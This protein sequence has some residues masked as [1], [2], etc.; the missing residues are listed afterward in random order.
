MSQAEDMLCILCVLFPAWYTVI[1]APSN[2][3]GREH[4]WYTARDIY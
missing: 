4:D 1:L 3:I 2:D